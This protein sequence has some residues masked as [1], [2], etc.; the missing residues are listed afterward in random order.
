M[1]GPA[2]DRDVEIWPA[3]VVVIVGRGAFD[4]SA[5]LNARIRADIR[6]RSIAVVDINPEIARVRRPLHFL[7]HDLVTDE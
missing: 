7:A 3:V 5:E 2:H 1:I 4:H 6:E